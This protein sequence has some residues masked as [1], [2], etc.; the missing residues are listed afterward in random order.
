MNGKRKYLEDLKKTVRELLSD[1]RNSITNNK[2]EETL[3]DMFIAYF[4]TYSEISLMS[5]CLELLPPRKAKIENRDPTI[6]QES[7]SEMFKEIYGKEIHIDISTRL[8]D[9]EKDII[10]SYLDVM[11]KLVEAYKKKP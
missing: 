1:I 3:V 10:W 4:S 7:V 5:K 9:D 11:I 6:M 2:A 8:D